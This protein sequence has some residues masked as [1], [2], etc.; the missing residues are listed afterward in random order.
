MFPRYFNAYFGVCLLFGGE[1][2]CIRG[3]LRGCGGGFRQGSKRGVWIVN[4]ES[5][6][7]RGID[8]VGGHRCGVEGADVFSDRRVDGELA[9]DESRS[10][11]R[12]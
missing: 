8:C 2:A 9:C 5:D 10:V 6:I 7:S 12:W 3:S 1:L 4:N 11:R